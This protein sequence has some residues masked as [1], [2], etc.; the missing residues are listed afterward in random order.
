MLYECSPFTVAVMAKK[1]DVIGEMWQYV[2]HPVICKVA[3]RIR[4]SVINMSSAI[5]I[6][7]CFLVKSIVA[8]PWLRFTF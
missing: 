6:Y 3:Q 2:Y 4:C 8:C 1:D 7:S 5:P